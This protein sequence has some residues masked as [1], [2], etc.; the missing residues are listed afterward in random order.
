MT[1]PFRPGL[2]GRLRQHGRGDGRG[3]ACGRSRPV[4]GGRDPAERHAGRGRAT[5]TDFP[6]PGAAARHARL[7]AAEAGRGRAGAGAAA[8]AQTILVSI[9]AGV[10][11]ASLREPLSRTPRRSSAPCPTCRSRAPRCD[12]ACTATTPT[13]GCAA[14]C[15]QLFTLLGF[16]MVAWIDER[17]RV[18]RDRRGRRGGPGLCRAFI[19]AL[20]KAGD[21]RGLDPGIAPTVAL[22]TRARHRLRW[23]RHRRDRWTRSPA[24]SP[25]PTARPKRACRARPRRRPRRLVARTLDAAARRGAELAAEA[26]GREVDRSRHRWPRRAVR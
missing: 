3:L 17:G 4:A 15:S 5:V 20:A 6:R 26:R 13:T 21:A 2:A 23:P 7:Q 24:A 8:S 22:E 10:E 1:L 16:G 19:E 12:R 11:A 14:A 18:G 25:A 9:L